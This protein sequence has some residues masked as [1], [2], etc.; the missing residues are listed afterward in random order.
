MVYLKNARWKKVKNHPIPRLS[1][2]KEPQ[3]H[4]LSCYSTDYPTPATHSDEREREK[5]RGGGG[6]VGIHNP[7]KPKKK[8]Y[9]SPVSYFGQNRRTGNFF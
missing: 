5:I 6:G 2:A 4:P 8:R 1:L 7:L 3:N 9:G